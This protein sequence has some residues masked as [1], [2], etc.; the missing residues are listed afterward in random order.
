MRFINKLLFIGLF[1]G[2]T[3]S[4]FSAPP[5]GTVFDFNTS[6][7]KVTVMTQ[8]PAA[9]LTGQTA[10]IM[11]DK[12]E[13]GQITIG[14]TYHTKF[15][16]TLTSGDSIKKNDLVVLKQTDAGAVP[17]AKLKRES[18]KDKAS[19]RGWM[20]TFFCEGMPKGSEVE[21]KLNLGN[22]LVF[23]KSGESSFSQVETNTVQSLHFNWTGNSL[24]GKSILL[25]G[26][27]NIA[28]DE[29]FAKN[30]F[31]KFKP[32]SKYSGT[33]KECKIV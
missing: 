15:L 6:T 3:G 20:V 24:V 13:V 32:D 29:I 19:G 27:K 1:C 26:N 23:K 28:T 2:I 10:F 9:F 12:K 31:G 22:Q 7:K 11:R 21:R 4:I 33:A 8:N 25:K 14:L 18:F 17:P 5:S 30:V 16:G